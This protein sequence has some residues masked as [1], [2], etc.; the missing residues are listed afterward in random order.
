MKLNL[1]KKDGNLIPYS[2]DDRDRVDEFKDGAIY[3]VNINNMDKRTILQNKLLHKFCDNVAVRLNEQEL[4]VAE[5]IKFETEWTMEKV[6]ELIFKP[7]V[8]SLY[9]K[10]STT[11]L[12]KKEF[13]LI[14]DTIIQALAYK[15]VDTTNLLKE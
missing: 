15:S 14:F 9:N 13:D 12:N 2:Q 7:V 4:K 8:K 3:Q 10:D 1:I 11:K 5:V 6:K